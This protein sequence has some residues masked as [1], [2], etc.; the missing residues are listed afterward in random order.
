MPIQLPPPTERRL[1]A[2]IQR[3][4]EQELEQEIGELKARLVLDFCL[5]EIAPSVYNQAI[6]DAQARIQ[7]QVADLD[8]A[9]YQTEFGY[10]KP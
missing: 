8:G 6:A 5:R 3:Y 7:Q 4:F 1:L 2:S 9:C 10:W